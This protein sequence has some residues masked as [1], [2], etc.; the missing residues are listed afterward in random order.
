M[1]RVNVDKFLLISGFLFVLL[2][3]STSNRLLATFDYKITAAIS[4]IAN[5][6]LDYFLS[7]FTLLGSVEVYL[8]SSFI[9]LILLYKGRKVKLIIYYCLFFFFIFLIEYTGKTYLHQLRPPL[10]FNRNLLKFGILHI[11]APY[12]FPSGHML[13]FTFILGAIY[14]FLLK[15]KVNSENLYKVLFIALIMIMALSRVYLGAH[16]MSDIIGGFLCATLTLFLLIRVSGL[17]EI[18]EKV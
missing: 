17:I 10:E 11:K 13:K 3:I 1:K 16:W 8:L 5:P 9:I 6:F 12:S 4:L 18:S 14:Y 7:I 15:G 2:S